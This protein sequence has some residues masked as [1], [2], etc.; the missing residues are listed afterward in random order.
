MNLNVPLA[1]ASS[2][3]QLEGGGF[4]LPSRKPELISPVVATHASTRIRKRQQLVGSNSVFIFS[5]Y[6]PTPDESQGHNTQPTSLHG[7]PTRG[8]AAASIRAVNRNDRRRRR[9]LVGIETQKSQDDCGHSAPAVAPQ[10]AREQ[11][12]EARS[13]EEGLGASTDDTGPGA[14]PARQSSDGARPLE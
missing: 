9:K 12:K 2:P 11:Q 6:H 5:L 13:T 7:R 3:P 1:T 8:G 4:S 10:A 14:K